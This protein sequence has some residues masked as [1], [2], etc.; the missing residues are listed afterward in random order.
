MQ[1]CRTGRNW[2]D[3]AAPTAIRHAPRYG[4]S[5]S[6]WSCAPLRRRPDL[7]LGTTTFALAPRPGAVPPHWGPRL[8]PWGHG[9]CPGP[10]SGALPPLWGRAMRKTVG[11]GRWRSKQT[12]FRG[13]GSEKWTLLSVVRVWAFR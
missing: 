2:C 7:A 8:S 13:I 12:I 5:A 9:L 1:P 3:A 6:L 10:R 4:V 11:F